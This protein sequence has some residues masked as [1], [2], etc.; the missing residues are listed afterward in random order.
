MRGSDCSLVKLRVLVRQ[1]AIQQTS[2]ATLAAENA[3][4]KLPPD[5]DLP[6]RPPM[7][8]LPGVRIEGIRG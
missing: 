2:T 5:S 4:H 8:S 3:S 1:S 7:T 6:Q